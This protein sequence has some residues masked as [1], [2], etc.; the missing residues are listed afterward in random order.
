VPEP[1][2]W[3]LMLAGAAGMGALLRRRRSAG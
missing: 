1:D 3:A 2:S